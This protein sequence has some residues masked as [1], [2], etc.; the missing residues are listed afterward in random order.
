[1]ISYCEKLR[2]CKKSI[3]W[4]FLTGISR[5]FKNENLLKKHFFLSPKLKIHHIQTLL[6]INTQLF[7][8]TDFGFRPLKKV[9]FLTD[10]GFF[11][12]K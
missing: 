11:S 8:V 4:Q 9:F 7:Y 6:Y 5:K 10:S 1:M 3:F 12:E 2:K